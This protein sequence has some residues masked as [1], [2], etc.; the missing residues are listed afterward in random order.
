MIL[1]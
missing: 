1:S